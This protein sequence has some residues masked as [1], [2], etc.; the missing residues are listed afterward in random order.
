MAD[1]RPVFDQVNLVVTDMAASVGFYRLLGLDIHDT[2]PAWQDHHRTAE[3]G[4]GLDLDLD[5][6]EFARK[7]N[8][9]WPGRAPGG[10]SVLG[11]KFPS[12]QAVDDA[13]ARLT[14]AGHRGQQPPYD[15]FW[16]AR[17]AVV[18]DPDGNAVGLMSPADD[19]LRSTP[20]L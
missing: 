11:F 2:L 13:Y 5:S 18:E 19:A 6:V 9:G 12:R 15:A 14:S 20:E 17:Y 3:M 1:D 4:D 8:R 16:G 10:M 7:W